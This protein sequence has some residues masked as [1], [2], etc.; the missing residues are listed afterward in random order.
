MSS[1]RTRIMPDERENFGFSPNFAPICISLCDPKRRDILRHANVWHDQRNR[2]CSIQI[3]LCLLPPS[4]I[5][6]ALHV[7]SCFRHL[8]PPF[9]RLRRHPLSHSLSAAR[10]TV[11]NADFNEFFKNSPFVS[12]F[13]CIGGFVRELFAC[14]KSIT[15]EEYNKACD[16]IQLEIGRAISEWSQIEQEIYAFLR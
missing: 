15:E 9:L 1:A 2:E 13:G 14:P 8:F 10:G 11:F 5:G 12:L 3:S 16:A 4:R 6:K 7:L